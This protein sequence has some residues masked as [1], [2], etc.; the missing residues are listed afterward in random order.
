MVSLALPTLVSAPSTAQ[1]LPGGYF[2]EHAPGSEHQG[3]TASIV[4]GSSPR[5]GAHVSWE[6]RKF[7]WVLGPDS[8]S[9]RVG[10]G[11]SHTS[12]VGGQWVLGMDPMGSSPARGL[13]AA[14]GRSP[15]HPASA[16]TQ[17]PCAPDC[18]SQKPALP[19]LSLTWQ[20]PITQPA[21]RQ[22]CSGSRGPRGQPGSTGRTSTGVHSWAAERTD[23]GAAQVVSTGA[24]RKRTRVG[25][26]GPRNSSV[27]CPERAASGSWQVP[28][29]RAG[30]NHGVPHKL[31]SCHRN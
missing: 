18:P 30:T 12:T 22:F 11:D 15:P 24:G 8:V 31:W 27:L 13:L 6:R 21:L 9:P 7:R 25:P 19:F 10:F 2:L 17:V 26:P 28:G 4:V 3:L 14:P 5:R 1:V 20:N 29:S 16:Q 23:V